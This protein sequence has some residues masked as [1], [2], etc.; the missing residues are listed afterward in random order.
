M[1]RFTIRDVLWLM[2]VVG[3]AISLGTAWWFE[4][5]RAN[6]LADR[7]DLGNM[8]PDEPVRLSRGTAVKIYS[9]DGQVSLES[10]P[11]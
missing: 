1:F 2:V 4:R 8:L 7:I 11:K 5:S 6:E 10:S 3:V 9:V